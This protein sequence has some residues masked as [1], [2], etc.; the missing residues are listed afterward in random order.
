MGW[1]AGTFEVGPEEGS[2]LHIPK[3]MS[4]VRK[5]NTSSI[6]FLGTHGRRVKLRDELNLFGELSCGL[7]LKMSLFNSNIGPPPPSPERGDEA[8]SM[9][10][11]WEPPAVGTLASALSAPPLTM[12]MTM[13]RSGWGS[14]CKKQEVKGRPSS[15]WF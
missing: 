9:S 2:P 10:M 3:F 7:E 13:T 4:N 15:E 1:M 6:L 8:E 14:G 12:T 11:E 5:H